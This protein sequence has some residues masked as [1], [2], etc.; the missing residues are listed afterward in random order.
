M[1]VADGVQAALPLPPPLLQTSK[2]CYRKEFKHKPLFCNNYSQWPWFSDSSTGEVGCEI[3]TTIK[4]CKDL[5]TPN[6][7]FRQAITAYTEY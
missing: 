4:T 6:V 2:S 7:N 3:L 5:D 1:W